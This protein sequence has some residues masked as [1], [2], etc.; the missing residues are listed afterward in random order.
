MEIE[1][2]HEPRV[3]VDSETVWGIPASELPAPP[4][5]A[6]QEKI[7]AAMEANDRLIADKQIP[8]LSQGS[9]THYG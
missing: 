8:D 7:A 5:K 9:E 4:T 2:E 1:H 3:P 6:E